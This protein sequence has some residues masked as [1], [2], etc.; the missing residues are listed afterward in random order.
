MPRDDEFGRIRDAVG[1]LVVRGFK[2]GVTLLHRQALR[3]LGFP[4]L[5]RA[6]G[7]E[8]IYSDECILALG[9]REL[10]FATQWP[11][12]VRFTGPVRYTPPGLGA[13]PA[14]T[15]GRAH[16][17]V[18]LGTHLRVQKERV[19]AAIRSAAVALPHV[20][21]H[22]T[23]GRP[24]G[25]NTG[26]ANDSDMASQSGPPYASTPTGRS[27]PANFQR[28]PFIDYSL[29]SRYDLVVHHAGAGVLYE[30]M[31][32]GLPAIVWPL[33]YDQFDN[34]ARLRAAG[35][36]TPLGSLDDLPR[37]IERVLTDARAPRAIAARRHYQ[38]L[39]LHGG[40]AEGVNTSVDTCVDTSSQNS[41]NSAVDT[42]AVDIASSGTSS[43]TCSQTPEDLIAA[44]V[45]QRLAG[46]ARR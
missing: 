31:A 8:A 10:E 7:S 44:L 21:F 14:F 1:R 36:A 30:T 20:E 32:A 2:R 29:I 3:T 9:L 23:D 43:Q 33:D 38:H 13:M 46:I 15:P 27:G 35:L 11:A 22:F 41:E 24:A 19:A 37:T 18:S 4:G 6:D 5:Y 45:H 12:A 26:P 40:R 34:A 42:S 25:A 28:L 39:V 16:V 17:L